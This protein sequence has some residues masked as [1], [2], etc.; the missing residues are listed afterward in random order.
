MSGI[1]IGPNNINGTID[2]IIQKIGKAK[3]VYI[4]DKKFLKVSENIKTHQVDTII[5][6]YLFDTMEPEDYKYIKYLD[7]IRTRSFEYINNIEN[8]KIEP[9]K[10]MTFGTFDL[11]HHGHYNILARA[12]D[13]GTELITGVSSDELNKL[14]GKVSINPIKTR[15][16]DTMGTGFVSECFIEESLEK[17]DE[18]IKNFNCNLLAMGDDWL[19]RFDW[20]S[21]PCIYFPRTPGI[22]TTLLKQISGHNILTQ[23]V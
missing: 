3:L 18:Y 2:E 6:Y 12:R 23:N 8:I 16:A 5:I 10:V 19:G 1:T 22:S 21:V 13:L 4:L 11:F 15:I 17:K 14:K 9:I 20:V 7:V